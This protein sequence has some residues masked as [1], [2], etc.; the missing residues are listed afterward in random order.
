MAITSAPDG[1]CVTSTVNALCLRVNWGAVDGA[2]G[3]HVYRSPVPHDGFSRVATG[4]PG[5][6][7]FD[8]PQ[9]TYNLNL[10]RN[11]WYYKVS[12]TDGAEGPLSP[13]STFTPYGQLIHDNVPVPGLSQWS[14]LF[15]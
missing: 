5:L 8:N 10:L 11:R 2:T 13:P 6:T 15:Y 7:Y 1:V 12:A 3:Y 9:S 14:A 4:V